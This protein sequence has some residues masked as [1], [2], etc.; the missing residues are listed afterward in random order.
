MGYERT[1]AG[2]GD[3]AR[4]GNEFVVLFAPAAL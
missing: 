3:N 2:T 1:S 4:E